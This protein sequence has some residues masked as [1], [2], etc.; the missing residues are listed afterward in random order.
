MSALLLGSLIS[1]A[2]GAAKAIAGGVQAAK[3]NKQMKNLLANRPQYSIPEAYQKALGV[4]GNLA[5]SQMP[6]Q[7]YYEDRIGESTARTISNAERGAI[8]SNV[9]QGAVSGAQD[10]ELQAIQDLAKMG[11]EYKTTQVQNYGQALNQYGQLQDQA[12]EYNTNQPWQIKANMANEQ[13]MAGQ[14]NLFGGLGDMGASVMN[15]VG[16]KYYTDMLKGFQSQP[17]NSTAGWNGQ[18]PR[19]IDSSVQ[20]Y[21]TAASMMPRAKYIDWENRKY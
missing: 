20:L 6:G 9:F 2:F 7:Q 17:S 13:K 14:Q 4:Y 21:G 5:S 16:T 3:G 18:M 10:K 19:G 15:F 11:A 8:S 1:G 12:F